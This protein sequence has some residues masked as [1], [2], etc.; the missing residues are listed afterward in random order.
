MD[1][2]DQLR[3]QTTAVCQSLTDPSWRRSRSQRSGWR[4]CVRRER[5]VRG[6]LCQLKAMKGR[7]C[8]ESRTS[9]IPSRNRCSEVQD[10]LSSSRNIGTFHPSF[11]SSYTCQVHGH[12]LSSAVADRAPVFFL[13]VPDPP[14]PSCLLETH[15]GTKDGEDHGE[16]C[17]SATI[18]SLVDGGDVQHLVELSI[19]YQPRMPPAARASLSPR[20][21]KARAPPV[22]APAA[23]HL[24]H[25]GCRYFDPMRATRLLSSC[26]MFQ[27]HSTGHLGHRLCVQQ[28]YE[29][30]HEMI[31]S[32]Q[33]IIPP[34]FPLLEAAPINSPCLLC[35][36][37]GAAGLEDIQRQSLEASS[38]QEEKKVFRSVFYTLSDPTD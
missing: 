25:R 7:S 18:S 17:N 10:G 8:R 23:M 11:P 38:S 36:S 12:S 15:R 31:L 24:A 3:V 37:C 16:V 32:G 35:P 19:I 6:S 29:V 30:R 34:P 26:L 4:E 9:D 1:C 21:R 14:Y 33:V 13:H 28:S 22:V 5:P 27:K 2:C 20:N